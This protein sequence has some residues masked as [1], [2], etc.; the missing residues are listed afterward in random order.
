MDSPFNDIKAAPFRIQ[1]PSYHIARQRLD[2][3]NAAY[4]E[5]CF[6]TDEYKEWRSYIDS[7]DLDRDVSAALYWKYWDQTNSIPEANEVALARCLWR[8]TWPSN[9]WNW[10]WNYSWQSNLFPELFPGPD[11]D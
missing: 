7:P 6:A 9:S 5:A 11:I 8:C 3:A 1:N 4:L 2:A 10:H